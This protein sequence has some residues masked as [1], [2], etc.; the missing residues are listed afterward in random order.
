MATNRGSKRLRAIHERAI[1]RFDGVQE[2]SRDVRT[3]CVIDRRMVSVPGAMWEGQWL[4][5]WQNKPKLEINKLQLACTRII[6]EYRQNPMSVRFISQDGKDRDKLANLCNSLY[7]A[8]MQ[9]SNADEAK[10]N[11]FEEAISGGFG[12]YRLVTK[13][14]DEYSDDDRQ[15]VCFEPIYDAD[16]SVFFDYGAKKQDKSDAKWAFVVKSMSPDDYEEEFGDDPATWPK[17]IYEGEF[18]WDAPDV[19]YVAEYY[20]IEET[21]KYV[22]TYKLISGE[23]VKLSEDELTEEKIAELDATGSTILS[24]KPRKTRQVRKYIMSGGSVL[25]DCGVIAGKFIPIIPVFGK[26]WFVDNIERFQGHPRVSMDAA[27]IKN[28][29]MSRLAEIAAKSTLEKPI[30]TPEQMSGHEMRWAE[31]NIVDYPFM[32]VNPMITSDGQSTAQGP[33]GYTK[34]PAV[35]PALAALMM[36][37]DQDMKEML[38]NQDGGDRMISG[39]SGVAT[40]AIQQRIDMQSQIYITNMAKAE[41]RC[42]EVWLSMA[43]EILVEPGR[44]VK[45][46]DADEKVGYKEIKQPNLDPDTG[47][48]IYDNDLSEASFDIAV[49]VGP[50]SDS[51]R[52]AAVRA[53]TGMMAINQDPE[54]QQVLSALAMM[55]MQAEGVEE[56]RGFFRNKLLKMGAVA[57]TEEEAAQMAEAAHAAAS[58]P[59]DAN[60][61]YLQAAAA[62][63]A[64]DAKKSES[65]ALLNIA[66]TEETNAKTAKT[67]SDMEIAEREQFFD[68]L[69]RLDE[70]SVG[71]EPAP[72]TGLN[73][74]NTGMENEQ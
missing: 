6:N 21:K 58:Q 14:E 31:D 40:E 12:A 54:T 55:N 4:Q 46:V 71:Q 70:A 68:T 32:L 34:P 44:N 60:T 41:K 7:R 24:R 1:R 50:A 56:T 43:R 57:P 33:V 29:L 52:Q 27:R 9:D 72:P 74:A 39:V 63:A 11:A 28:M 23:E 5:Q 19:V 3:Q 69:N 53:I 20:E 18:D 65:T 26:R 66:K 47:E 36:Q 15:R 67:V 48:V 73:G 22:S 64:A 61:A 8:D 17:D 42:G 10:D 2:A 49:T 35:P 51:K 16:S 59:P 38:G 25:E 45:T 62:Q 30:F 37:V 13:Y